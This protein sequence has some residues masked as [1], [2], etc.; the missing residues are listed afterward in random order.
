[1][2]QKGEGAWPE[3]GIFFGELIAFWVLWPTFHRFNINTDQFVDLIL[4][5]HALFVSN[6]VQA[7]KHL[8]C[9]MVRLKNDLQLNVWHV[10]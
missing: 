1:M 4:I 5:L 6:V 2:I 3:R 9:Q 10:K 8:L 7:L